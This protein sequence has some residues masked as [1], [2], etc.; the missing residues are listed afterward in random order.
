MNIEPPERPRGRVGSR[1]MIPWQMLTALV[2]VTVTTSS[3]AAAPVSRRSRWGNS[4]RDR[5][6]RRRGG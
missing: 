4:R 3:V 5:W 6:L 1:L 2:I